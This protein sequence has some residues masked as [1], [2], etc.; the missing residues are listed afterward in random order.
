MEYNDADYPHTYDALPS[1]KTLLHDL[2]WDVACIFDACRWDA[3]EERCAPSQPVST[4]VTSTAS[5]TED[6]WCDPDMDWSNIT[7][8]TANPVTTITSDKDSEKYPG[9]MREHVGEYIDL[10]HHDRT[11]WNQ[12][13]GTPMA[14]AITESVLS[15]IDPSPPFVIHYIQPHTPFIGNVGFGIRSRGPETRLLNLFDDATDEDENIGMRDYYPVRSGMVDPAIA[16]T[17]Y[18][19]NLTRI[20]N[21]TTAIREA[22]DRVITTAD[23]GEQLG[24]DDWRH[25]HDDL[26]QA[27]V[28]PFHTTW[29]ATT[30]L[31]P[32]VT[33]ASD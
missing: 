32:Y 8:I 31:E 33:A 13:L 23:H 30:D 15:D 10:K 17:A 11:V 25:G 29:D 24:P 3:F 18:L 7:Y 9:D 19:E 21:E 14:D 1:V 6:V 27:R 2:D 4:P 22:H 16:R 26:N 5:W 28:V 12:D 20:W